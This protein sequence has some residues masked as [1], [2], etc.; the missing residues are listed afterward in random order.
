MA[1]LIAKQ[2]GR[3]VGLSLGAHLTRAPAPASPQV[4][5]PAR[6]PV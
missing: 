3:E 6:R 1:G 2:A 5:S 4:R